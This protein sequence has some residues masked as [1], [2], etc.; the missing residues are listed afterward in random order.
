M[1]VWNE[2]MNVESR[3]EMMKTERQPSALTRSQT[4]V[5]H[6][7]SSRFAVSNRTTFSVNTDLQ[8][9]HSAQGNIHSG[10]CSQQCGQ[11]SPAISAKKRD[12]ILD[13]LVSYNSKL[14]PR[15]TLSGWS[16]KTGF[17][18][19]KVFIYLQCKDAFPSFLWVSLS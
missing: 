13:V 15:D 16:W 14:C 12:R 2:E 5:K 4:G 9:L 19:S 11:A 17:R 3:L 6:R 18:K 10:H 8:Q 1:S 7:H